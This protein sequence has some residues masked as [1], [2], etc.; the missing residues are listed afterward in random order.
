MK[1][2]TRSRYG[3]R[4]VL[5]LA[6]NYGNGPLQIKAI[7][8]N[9]DISNKYLEQLISIL[10]SAGMVRSLRGPR[11]GYMLVNHPSEVTLGDVFRVLE[12]PFV[13]VE[14]IGDSGY[15]GRYSDCLMREVWVKLQKSIDDVL[16]AITMQDLVE[17]YG[18]GENVDFHI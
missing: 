12:G 9:E 13:P 5:D 10:K 11:G 15:C 2:S 18:D 14:C 17:K 7:A 16:D 1:L 6:R 8:Q 4:A 3:M